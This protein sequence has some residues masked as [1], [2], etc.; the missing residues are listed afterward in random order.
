MRRT[1][2]IL[3]VLLIFGLGHGTSL[4]SV[5]AQKAPKPCVER[6]T[7]A[8]FGYWMWKQDAQVS[9]YVR[10]SDFKDKELA[11]IVSAIKVWDEASAPNGSG[12]RFNYAGT[13]SSTKTGDNGLTIMRGPTSRKEHRAEIQAFSKR[14]DQVIDYAAITIDPSVKGADALTNALAHEIGHSLGLLDCYS[15][16]QESTAMWK[17]S[18]SGTKAPTECDNE[19]VKEAYRQLK[20]FVR[21]AP[22]RDTSTI[23]DEGE[24]PVEDD[25]PVVE[26]KPSSE[27]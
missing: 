23:V 18:S 11:A 17:L 27:N 6:Q 12:V 15:C 9:V 10:A 5:S 24:E 20:L 25:T 8:P 21:P 3:C 2:Q 4:Q 16:K 19:Q 22:A 13:T 7:A 1:V 14:G 26:A